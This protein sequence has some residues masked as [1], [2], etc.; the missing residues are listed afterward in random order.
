MTTAHQQARAKV[1]ML[2]GR[3]PDPEGTR[4]FFDRLLSENPAA[5]KT[6][7]H[8]EGLLADVLALASWSPL[9]GMTLIQNPPYIAW[10]GRE[11]LH[12]HVKTREELL[13]SLARFA[14]TNTQLDPSALLARFRRRELLRIYLKD[15]RRIANIVEITEE[16]SNLADTALEYGLR[17]ASQELENLYGSPLTIDERGRSSIATTCIMALGK[18]GSYELNYASDIDL[19]FIYSKDGETTGKGTRSA[20]TNRE[21][22]AKL[23][24]AVARIVGS[25]T[26]EGAPYRVDLRLRPHGRDGALSCSLDEAVRYYREVAHPWE[27]QTLIRSRSAA[28]SAELYTGFAEGVQHRV[29]RT[30]ETVSRALA[31]VRLAKRKI[32]HHHREAKGYNVKLGRGGIREIEFIAQALQLAY[33]GTDTWLQ[34]PHTLISLG[35]LADRGL[36]SEPERSS[37]SDAYSFLRMLE[38]R[39]QMENGLQTHSLPED[40]ERRRLV[41]RRMHYKDGQDAFEEALTTHT[42]NVHA[43]FT[44]VFGEIDEEL[45]IEDELPKTPKTD[46]EA[47]Q[48]PE[49]VAATDIEQAKLKVIASIF[50]SKYRETI[51]RTEDESVLLLSQRILGALHRSLNVQRAL[52]GLERVA[53]SLEKSSVEK[54]LDDEHMEALVR[55]CGTSEYFC[56]AVESNPALICALPVE[57]SSIEPPDYSM[58]LMEGVRSETN[59]GAQLAAIRKIWSKCILEIGAIDA[60]GAISTRESNRRQSNLAAAS[61]NAGCEIARQELLRRYGI[62]LAGLQHSVLGLGRLSGGGLDYGS[63][64]DIVL[65]YDDMKPSPHAN[66]THAEVMS[67]FVELLV[68]ALSSITREGQLYRVDLRLRP[69]GKNGAMAVPAR[70]FLEYLTKRAAYWEWLAYVKLHAVAGDLSFGVPVEQEARRI[71]HEAAQK[72]PVEAL[73]AETKRVRELLEQERKRGRGQ[74]TDIKYGAGGMLDVYFVARYLQLRHNVPDRNPDRSTLGTLSRLNEAGALGAEEYEWL[75]EGYALLRSVDHQLRMIIG[76]STR[77]RGFDHPALRDLAR[78]LDFSSSTELLERLSERM[79]K[80]RLAYNRIIS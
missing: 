72:A 22:F 24:G 54:T 25:T 47:L 2:V 14:L 78:L 51:G 5:A 28:G 17:L 16:L 60:R 42:N 21:Y 8:N 45:K 26:G 49:Q 27:L 35:R 70:A 65:V 23:A 66:L 7:L 55:L 63:D 46:V 41:A 4:L 62:E 57:N 12:T 39:L 38:H 56:D 43:V 9:L 32:D 69:D 77:L 79:S 37:L 75:H 74:V 52:K 1:E 3:M 58:L 80:V 48:P 30:N 68:A 53:F 40:P 19:Q 31:H 13:E 73:R 71:I 20:I 29:Y 11:R 50:S 44:R 18:L 10:L 34:A 67:R 59:F 36:I 76:R 15:I 6:L 61:L 33:G 64:L